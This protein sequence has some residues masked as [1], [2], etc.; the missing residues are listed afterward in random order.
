[1]KQL[2]KIGRPLQAT[3]SIMKAG[4]HMITKRVIDGVAP[5]VR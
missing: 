5:R 1:M 2:V 4:K 3:P